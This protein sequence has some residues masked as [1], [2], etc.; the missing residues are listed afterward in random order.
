[1]SGLTKNV[2]GPGWTTTTHRRYRDG[3][4]GTYKT[5]SDPYGHKFRSLRSAI[6]S[7]AKR[8]KPS[9]ATVRKKQQRAKSA[10]SEE[11]DAPVG[12]GGAAAEQ[13]ESAEQ[14]DIENIIL[15]SAREAEKATPELDW[16]LIDATTTAFEN[17]VLADCDQFM[18][19]DCDQ[20]RQLDNWALFYSTP[21]MFDLTVLLG[22]NI[23]EALDCTPRTLIGRGVSS[24]WAINPGQF[25]RRKLATNGLVHYRVI[26]DT[27]VDVGRGPEYP[28][29]FDWSCSHKPPPGS[30]HFMS[31]MA[32]ANTAVQKGCYA[33]AT[34]IFIWIARRA[35]LRPFHKWHQAAKTNAEITY[36]QLCL[37]SDKAPP[38]WKNKHK[39]TATD[40]IGTAFTNSNYIEDAL[41]FTAEYILPL[42]KRFP[43]NNILIFA[44]ETAGNLCN[45]L[46]NC[47][48]NHTKYQ[49]FQLMY[50]MCREM[51]MPMDK[52][53]S[54]YARAELEKCQLKRQQAPK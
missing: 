53:L 16:T 54:P 7:I 49:Q 51:H 8:R 33:V 11:T 6:R 40:Y 22:D 14:S 35:H 52:L 24:V 4:R 3:R 41:K 9:S 29:T 21:N 44:K 2:L 37:R 5:Y 50:K 42:H 38:S 10:I 39:L 23:I 20:L 34:V 18:Q 27:L 13:Q 30:F 15:A 28:P 19:T 25:I 31:A 48:G 36:Y 46:S 12:G 32:V 26:T 45:R 47:K 43:T 17:V 1:M